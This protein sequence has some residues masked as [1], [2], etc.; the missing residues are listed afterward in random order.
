MVKRIFLFMAV[1]VLV[2]LTIS[3]LL[4]VLGI[5]PYLRANGIDYG[6][7]AAF[8]LVWGMGGAFIS[9]ALSKVMAKWSMGV[10]IIDPNTTDPTLRALVRAVDRL[11]QSAGIPMPEVGIYESPEVNAFATGPTKRSSLVA[12]S[13]GLLQRMD[14][15][16]V[17]G[18]LSHEIA[19]VANG[20][21]VTM[22]LIQ[23]VV[24]A[25]V[26]FLA[27]VIAFA[28]AQFMSRDRD[29]N[30][31]MSYGIYFLVQFVCEIVFMVLGTIVVAWFSRWREF[32]ADAGG[33]QIGGRERMIGALEALQRTVEIRDP[34]PQEAVATLKI[35]NPNG[36]M[37]FFMTHP[38][39][40]E[41]IA[42]LRAAA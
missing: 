30:E 40:E 39:L 6:S 42:R 4:S 26:M 12:V 17:E 24:N 41:R 2:V 7:L 32:R 13:T 34:R 19:H 8:C 16:E 33:A 11:A 21:M 18:V 31:G 36:M 15:P 23:G 5:Q 35:S 27:R 29:D 37:R 38:P 1:N 22:T 28:A 20:D 3:V 14:Q 25:F 9:L 10:Q